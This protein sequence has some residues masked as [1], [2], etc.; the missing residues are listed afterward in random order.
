MPQ[1]QCTKF[2]RQIE[3]CSANEMAGRAGVNRRTAKRYADQTDWNA[4]VTERKSKSPV[5]EL[6]V[7]IVDT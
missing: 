3:R 1:Q 2:L 6:V 4:S 7:E 5:M